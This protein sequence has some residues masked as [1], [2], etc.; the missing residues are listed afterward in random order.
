M[1]YAV[2]GRETISDLS[3]AIG[4][5]SSNLTKE[6]TY[7][8]CQPLGGSIRI[9]EDGTTPTSSLGVKYNKESTFE[10]WGSDA[11]SAFRAIDDGGTATME[12]IYYGRGTS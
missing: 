12:V 4:F 3:S 1:I 6:V 10:V 8:L 5:T 9:T 2:V 7:A 11:L